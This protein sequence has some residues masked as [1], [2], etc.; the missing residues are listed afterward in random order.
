MTH[1]SNSSASHRVLP[2]GSRTHGAAFDRRVE[3]L[4]S[5]PFAEAFMQGKTSEPR[6]RFYESLDRLD[7][8]VAALFNSFSECSK[9]ARAVNDLV[10]MMRSHGAITDD[11]LR[12]PERIDLPAIVR[13]LQ[14][15]LDGIHV[16]PPGFTPPEH[17]KFIDSIG[18]LRDAG[19]E[20][21]NSLQFRH[22]SRVDCWFK[23]IAGSHVFLVNERRRLLVSLR[24]CGRG[25]WTIEEIWKRQ[26]EQ[27]VTSGEWMA[28]ER[29]FRG[30]GI[31]VISAPT[32]LLAWLD[33]ETGVAHD[34]YEDGAG[35]IEAA[36]QGL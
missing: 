21:G 13:R 25:V 19:H 15:G 8:S 24:S 18:A 14:R 32:R 27:Y 33:A 29:E 12:F 17:W 7:P 3:A 5:G 35:G 2:E 1:H 16:Q 34:E 22:E 31:K 6:V 28:V 9:T 11:D 30:A 36:I 10:T 20:I 23:L 26:S 4:C